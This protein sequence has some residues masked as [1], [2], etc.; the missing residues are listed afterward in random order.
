M[1]Q[2]NSNVNEINDNLTP[3][4]KYSEIEEEE[5]SSEEI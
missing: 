5:E 4:N 3:E 2:I 1:N